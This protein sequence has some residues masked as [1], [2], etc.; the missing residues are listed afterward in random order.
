MKWLLRSFFRG[1]LFVVPV[2]VTVYVLYWLFQKLGYLFDL[3]AYLGFGGPVVTIVAILVAITVIGFLASNVLT[4]W[5]VSLFEM[6]FKRV[7]LAK[8][9]YSSIKDLMEAFVGEEKKFNKPV[10]VSL[11]EQVGGEVLGFLTREDLAWLD[12]RESVAVY[13]PQSYN[14][15]GSVVIFPRDHITPIDADSSM[16]MQFIVS[17][18][19]SGGPPVPG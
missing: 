12:R 19:V 13:F 7:P 1:L 2:V 17:G 4:S 14:F 8:L 3:E 5:I 15:A 11:G 10:I 16:V 6:F 18:G 9:I